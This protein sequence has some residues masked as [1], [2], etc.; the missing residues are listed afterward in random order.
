MSCASVKEE[1]FTIWRNCHTQKAKSRAHIII[2]TRD[3]EGKEKSIYWFGMIQ[4]TNI[5]K[6]QKNRLPI[7]KCLGAKCLSIYRHPLPARRNGKHKYNIVLPA[8]NVVFRTVERKMPHN[9][10]TS[11]MLMINSLASSSFT[12]EKRVAASISCI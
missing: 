2:Q 9:S 7:K 3:K 8:G 5:K 4:N 12:Q 1:S 10:R 11:P 6:K